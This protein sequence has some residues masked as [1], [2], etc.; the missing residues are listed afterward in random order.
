MREIEPEIHDSPKKLP[1][2]RYVRTTEHLRGFDEIY[3]LTSGNKRLELMIAYE[4]D[5]INAQTHLGTIENKAKK[6]GS[7]TSCYLVAKDLMQELASKK[8]M[9]VDYLLDTT[10]PS[11][12]T[13]ARTAGLEIFNFYEASYG[14]SPI[15]H[16]I[17][18]VARATINPEQDSKVRVSGNEKG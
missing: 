7:T 13:W 18:F 1:A 10:E 6:D 12:I 2:T 14:W 15:K 11:M 8:G 16:A 9:R 5:R 4:A 3:Q 17:R